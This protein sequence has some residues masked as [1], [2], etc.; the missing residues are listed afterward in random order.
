[1]GAGALPDA[2]GPLT[3]PLTALA[4]PSG[5]ARQTRTEQA[6]ERLSGLCRV[7]PSAPKQTIPS[8]LTAV[9]THRPPAA[10]P[11]WPG[12]GSPAGLG[13]LHAHRGG[14]L[15]VGLGPQQPQQPPR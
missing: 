3:C 14:R 12:V 15:A 6:R 8:G 10:P 7:A 2:P 4:W 11:A 13:S 1:M 9:C 5:R